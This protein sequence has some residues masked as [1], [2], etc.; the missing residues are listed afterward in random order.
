MSYYTA[1]YIREFLENVPD[2]EPVFGGLSIREETGIDVDGE[3][4]T[5][6][7]PTPEEWVAMVDQAEKYAGPV[8]EAMWEV[9][10]DAKIDVIGEAE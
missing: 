7:I 6:R 3:E 5:I 4:F 9:L 10:N 8:F 1:K 2:D